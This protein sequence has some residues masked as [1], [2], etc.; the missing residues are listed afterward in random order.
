MNK[1]QQDKTLKKLNKEKRG[2]A[3]K[4][5]RKEPHKTDVAKSYFVLD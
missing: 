4:K 2:K 1:W 5:H 3:T